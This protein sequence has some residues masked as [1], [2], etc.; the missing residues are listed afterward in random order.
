[1]QRESDRATA[2]SLDLEP[3]FGVNRRI[4]FQIKLKKDSI[5]RYMCNKYA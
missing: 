1:M 4:Y 2:T 5:Q 3:G